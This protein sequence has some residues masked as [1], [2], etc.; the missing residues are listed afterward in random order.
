MKKVCVSVISL[1]IMISIGLSACDF[2]GTSDDDAAAEI[3]QT[4][5][6]LALT[7]TAIAEIPAPII[8]APPP[9]ETESPPEPEPLETEE[10]VIAPTA[11]IHQITPGNPGWVNKWFFDTD[12]SKTASQGYVTGGDDFI[13]NLFERPF[14]ET[15]MI[16]RPDVDI[17]KTEMSEDSNFYYVTI[18]LNGAHPEGGLQAAYGIEIDEDWDGRG[19][20]LV[21]ADRPSSTE[22]DIAGL[23]VWKDTNNDVGGS[24]ILRPDDNYAG[25]SYDQE[26]FSLNVLNDPD[27]A[28]ARI[29]IGTPASVTIAFKKSLLSRDTFVW[30]VWAADQ[31]L[32]PALFDH[33]DHFTQAEAGSPYSSHSTYPLK[34][35]NLIDNTCRETYNF[36]ATSPIPGLCYI[37]VPPTPTPTPTLPQPIPPDPQYGTISGVVFEDMN[38]NGRR[39]PGEP[40]T[41]YAGPPSLITISL[42]VDSCSTITLNTRDTA[43]FSFTD[44]S[45]GTYCVRI[46]GGPI[47]TTP[48]SYLIDLAGGETRYVEFGFEVIE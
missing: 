39:D 48:D 21:I 11:I 19:D 10:E 14:T 34:A 12:S 20:L 4:M 46:S 45:P 25:N 35:L 37:P 41:V 26:L 23:S 3:A 42:H 40:L 32:D 9:T 29:S 24:R 5:V 7:Q 6:A 47:T 28:W 38:G 17:N 13:A 22:W 30:G 31:L 44:L 36:E 15:E 8:E 1:L 43:N 18:Y 33:H 16:Y 27:A 2:S